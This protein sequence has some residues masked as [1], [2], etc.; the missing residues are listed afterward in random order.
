MTFDENSVLVS[1]KLAERQ[2][3]SVGDTITV[4]NK[5]GKQASLVISDIF[6]NYVGHYIYLS[7]STYAAAFGR[8]RPQPAV[9]QAA[10]RLG[11]GRCR[12]ACR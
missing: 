8:G 1:E 9:V 6:E 5:D 4:Q 12:V 3:W 7:Q 10:R 11:G 2:H